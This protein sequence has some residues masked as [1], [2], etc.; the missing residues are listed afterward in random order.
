MTG[1]Q[2]A[3]SRVAL[4]QPRVNCLTGSA[5]VALVAVGRMITDESLGDLLVKGFVIRT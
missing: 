4:P 2:E 5:S 1:G 3:L